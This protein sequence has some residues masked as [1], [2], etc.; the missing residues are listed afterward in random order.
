MEN[1]PVPIRSCQA[2]HSDSRNEYFKYIR[3]NSMSRKRAVAIAVMGLFLA[4]G[5][6]PSVTRGENSSRLIA[7]EHGENEATGKPPASEQIKEKEN[8]G[9]EFCPVSGEKIDEK[10]KVTY[11][12]KG[13]IYSFCCQDC[14]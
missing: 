2:R 10:T 9:N 6:F 12:Y 3:R 5:I 11:E 8:V 1:D 4:G 7:H 13:K 14:V